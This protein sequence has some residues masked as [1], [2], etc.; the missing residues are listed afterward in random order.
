MSNCT[1]KCSC[2]ATGTVISIIV[3]IIGAIVLAVATPVIPT[4]LYWA[5]LAS[6]V[7]FLAVTVV[8]APSSK[9][10]RCVCPA[11]RTLFTGIIGT[12]ITSVILLVINIATITVPLAILIGLLIVFIGLILTGL[13]CITKCLTDCD[14]TTEV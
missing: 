11:L 5:A 3:G 12:I 14:R 2:T 6:A 8:T 1:C 7:L 13:V 4:A 9:H 10:S